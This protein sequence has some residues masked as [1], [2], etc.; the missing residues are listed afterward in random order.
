MSLKTQIDALATAIGADIKAT[1]AALTT[2]INGKVGTARTITAGTGLTGGGSLAA[3]RTLAADFGTGAGKVTQGNDS[4]LADTRTPTAGTSPAPLS[5]IA[6][7]K[8][9]TRAAGTGDNP[10]GHKHQFATTYTSVTFR[11]ATADN[12]GSGVY[13]IQKNGA[14]VSG[15]TATVAA[16]S[17]VAGET[18]T[19]SWAFAV[20]DILTLVV[21][22]NGTGTVGKGLCADIKGTA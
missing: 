20:G 2:A 16:A 13:K 22:S 5:I 1:A 10:F 14:D 9:T 4:R 18:A 11:G 8:D 7:G 12:G 15:M 21:V 3:D 17:Q 19:G 6:F